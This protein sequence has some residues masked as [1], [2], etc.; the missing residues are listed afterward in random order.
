MKS[1]KLSDF[2]DEAFLEDLVHD[3]D[4]D[5]MARNLSDKKPLSALMKEAKE[6]SSITLPTMQAEAETPV[7]SGPGSVTKRRKTSVMGDVQETHVVMSPLLALILNQTE[8]LM[9]ADWRR[10]SVAACNLRG[11][12]SSLY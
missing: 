10:R 11:I 4:D 9:N 8:Y 2:I 6:L 7:A 5:T 12:L 3:V 1:V